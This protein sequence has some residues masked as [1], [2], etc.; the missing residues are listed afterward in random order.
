MLNNVVY[1]QLLMCGV[2]HMNNE[3]QKL[4]EK[5]DRLLKE[6]SPTSE[7]VLELSREVDLL[8]TEYY[9]QNYNRP[10]NNCSIAR[11]CA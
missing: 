8:I 10:A 11:G 4:K 3:L 6:E 2:K 9:K 7:D 1:I 5:L